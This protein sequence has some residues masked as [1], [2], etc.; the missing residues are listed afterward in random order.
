MCE[1]RYLQRFQDCHEPDPCVA[2]RWRAGGD[3]PWLPP[4]LYRAHKLIL[5]PTLGIAVRALARSGAGP[6]PCA[7]VCR[8]LASLSAARGC[9]KVWWV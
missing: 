8:G 1:I 6:G 4:D 5:P 2:A 9:T 7:E 3:P